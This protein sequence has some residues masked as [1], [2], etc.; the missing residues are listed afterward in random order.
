MIEYY[1]IEQMLCFDFEKKKRIDFII[2]V[3]S[4]AKNEFTYVISEK[5]NR[6]RINYLRL[7]IINNK[8]N[9]TFIFFWLL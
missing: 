8:P 1:N 9:V 7:Q 3:Q 6:S 2:W 5:R 4:S